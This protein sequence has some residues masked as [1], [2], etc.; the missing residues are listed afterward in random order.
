[1]VVKDK[2]PRRFL[3]NIRTRTVHLNNPTKPTCKPEPGDNIGFDDDADSL[4]LQRFNPC[5]FCIPGG[6][7]SV[8]TKDEE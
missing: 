7:S 6:Y 2:D 1:M 5:A 4:K 3:V 8:T